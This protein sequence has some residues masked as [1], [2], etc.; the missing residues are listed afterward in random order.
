MFHIH[1]LIINWI[2][3]KIWLSL[4]N[5]IVSLIREW[6]GFP[7]L[8]VDWLTGLMELDL[9]L[10]LNEIDW[11]EWQALSL[12][13][14]FH[15]RVKTVERINS[16]N[17]SNKNST[18]PVKKQQLLALNS[19]KSAFSGGSIP[20]AV[21]TGINRIPQ[22][23]Q[24]IR[25]SCKSNL[26]QLNPIKSNRDMFNWCSP[27]LQSDSVCNCNILSSIQLKFVNLTNRGDDFNSVFFDLFH[28]FQ[29]SSSW[30]RTEQV[31]EFNSNHSS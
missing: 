25:A 12:K 2:H 21:T 27:S 3:L 18:A 19:P 22:P 24:P 16:L 26:I 7:V 30:W 1:R 29:H 10:I 4:L 20:A 31:I 17:V 15:S 23:T 5:W 28:K 6:E 11:N 14:G 9:Y 8:N 13:F